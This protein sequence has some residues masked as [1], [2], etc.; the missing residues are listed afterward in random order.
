MKTSVGPTS[1]YYWRRALT[2]VL[3]AQLLFWS[4]YALMFYYLQP[5]NELEADRLTSEQVKLDPGAGPMGAYVLG[6]SEPAVLHIPGW[7]PTV[8]YP[9]RASVLLPAKTDESGP[10][11]LGCLGGPCEIT[12]TA[13]AG[14]LPRMEAAAYLER[15][16]RYDIVWIDIAVAVVVGVALLILLPISRFSR[17]QTVT[18]VF[19]ILLAPDA[20]LTSFGAAELPYAWFPVLRYGAEFLL[21][22]SMSITVNAFAGWRAREAWAA[23]ACFA[24]ALAMLTGTL[25]TGGDFTKVVPLL[26]AAALALLFGH[27]LFAML[28]LFRSAPGPAFRA[29]A[30]LFVA[31]ASVGF[32]VFFLLPRSNGL[33]L[34]SAI[35]SPPVLILAFL[36]ELA[37]QGRRLNQE[38]DEA[39]SDLERQ[40]LEQDASLLRSSSL[41]RHQARL[42][43]IDAERQR[44][45]R[46]MQEGAGGV[47]T[48]LLLDVRQNRL[49]HS[50]IERGLQSALDDLR[51]IA[52][53]IDAGDEPIDEA[54]AMF[55]ERV[56]ARLSRSG[57]VFNYRCV[58]PDPAPSLDVRRRL[59]LYRLLQ[60]GIANT[61][62]HAQASRIDLTVE[63][64]GEDAILITLSD[65][66]T[67]FDP[68]IANGSPVEGRGLANMRRRASQMGGHLFI[69]SAPKLGTRLT[70][71]VSVS[72]KG[73]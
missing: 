21:L 41:L 62:R 23:G 65:N 12:K 55:G 48:H 30:V 38:A 39:H 17:L 56:A 73:K 19:L 44:L 24:F 35:L 64:A 47:L 49:T 51:N 61:L 53:A 60:E 66:G 54:L 18:G 9:A 25:L 13:Y 2:I 69:E 32:D 72:I 46:D 29:L 50:E 59:S 71:S 28:R 43:A 45:L 6:L 3:G 27:G 5:P 68:I 22:T 42:I 52:S 36:F 33:T 31:L 58:L 67:G 26:E 11:S 37:L 1:C 57:I 63:A 34:Q 40:A 7:R 4:A 14:P 16:Q 20:W 15:F 10:W 70:L 8:I